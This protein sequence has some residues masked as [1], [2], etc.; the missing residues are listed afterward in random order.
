MLATLK[1]IRADGL[2]CRAVPAA[3]DRSFMAELRSRG[4]ELHVWTV[5]NVKTALYFQE[6]GARSIT[7]NRPAWLREQMAKRSR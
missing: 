1:E 3:I 6:L 2:D 5:D 4:L 7:T